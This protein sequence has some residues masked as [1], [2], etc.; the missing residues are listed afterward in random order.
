METGRARIEENRQRN[1][2]TDRA[3]ALDVVTRLLVPEDP[4]QHAIRASTPHAC[5]VI[6]LRPFDPQPRPESTSRAAL[7]PAMVVRLLS[8][9]KDQKGARK[10]VRRPTK[11]SG[12][13]GSARKARRG[14]T[15]ADRP[16]NAT[17]RSLGSDHAR[18]EDAAEA[19]RG[20][21]SHDE[22]AKHRVVSEQ[23]DQMGRG[24]WVR[25]NAT[26]QPFRLTRQHATRLDRRE[27]RTAGGKAM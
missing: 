4:A 9:R 18:P 3:S 10:R 20:R 15:R 5:P 27:I 21:A 6:S 25:R 7:F 17:H 11:Q 24:D 23:H 8:G 16:E 22:N 19:S 2:K 13:E 26:A 12:A 14:S 1:V